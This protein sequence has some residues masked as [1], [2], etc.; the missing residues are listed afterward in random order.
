M[1]FPICSFNPTGTETESYSKATSKPE[2]KKCW[3]GKDSKHKLGKED[4]SK[5]CGGENGKVAMGSPKP[6]H[7]WSSGVLARE[8][9]QVLPT[10]ITL[11]TAVHM[12]EPALS[13]H[14]W[15][16]DAAE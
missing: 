8:A 4:K 2:P 15:P 3:G 12:H 10:V 9:S 7:P 1:L 6:Q 11:S 13:N 14:A 16:D 5:R